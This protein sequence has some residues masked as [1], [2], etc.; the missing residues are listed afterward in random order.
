MP[1]LAP[2]KIASLEVKKEKTEIPLGLG[3]IG[4]TRVG[5]I[6]GP[7]SVENLD[8]LLSTAESVKASGAIALRGGAFKPRTSPYSFQGLQEEGLQ[9]LAEARRKT[10]LAIV[11]EV[12]SE[13]HV[14][15]IGR[16]ADCYQ[17]GAR[18]MQNYLL[19][20]AV[21]Q[22]R[23]PVLLKR[24]FAATI[25]ELLLAAE[26]ILREGNPN[27]ILCERGIRTFEDY[28]RNTLDLSAVP[29]LQEQTHL[30]VVVDPS[31]GTG[32]RSLVN[33]MCRGRRASHRSAPG[34]RAGDE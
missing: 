17:V 34:A 23:K 16:Y 8:E 31:H 25:Q 26:Y 1:I 13:N 11:T 27:V 15:L 29:A 24:G 2:F 12:M 3:S 4:G 30:P 5:V 21:G 19:L 32:K 10:G 33:A 20:K 7:C 9:Y 14:D 28:T 6:A 22:T 18:N